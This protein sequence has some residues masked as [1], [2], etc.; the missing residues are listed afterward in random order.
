MKR[1]ISIFIMFIVLL[2]YANISCYALEDDNNDVSNISTESDFADNRVIIAL[3][4]KTSLSFEQYDSSDFSSIGC[5]Q[6]YDLSSGSETKV[7]NAINNINSHVLE[8]EELQKYD[9]VALGEYRKI[10]CLE[11]D[12][13]SKENVINVINKLKQMDGVEYASPDYVIKTCSTTTASDPYS[14]DYANDNVDYLELIEL[15]DAWEITRGS[16]SVRVGVMDSGIDAFHEDLQGNVNTVISGSFRNGSYVQSEGMD[17][18]YHGTAVAGVIGAKAN[19][20]KGLAGVCNNIELVSFIISDPHGDA[21]ASNAL[22]AFNHIVEINND[23]CIDNDIHIINLSLSWMPP[24]ILEPNPNYNA[25]INTGITNYGKLVVCSAGNKGVDIDDT[26]VYPAT[27]HCPNVIVVGATNGAD[28]RWYEVVKDKDGNDVVYETN[29]GYTSVDLFAPGY[30]I[31]TTFPDDKCRDSNVHIDDIAASCVETG[32]HWLSGTSFATP[33]VTGVA[34]LMLSINPNLTAVQLKDIITRTV[35]VVPALENY[36]VSGGRLNAYKAVRT[37]QMYYWNID[38]TYLQLDTTNTLYSKAHGVW[39]DNCEC[40]CRNTDLSCDSGLCE[41]ACD[42]CEDCHYYFTELH[43]Y[44]YIST[45]NINT[46]IARCLDCGYEY[47][48]AHNMYYA[49]ILGNLYNHSVK[50]SACG[51][52]YSEGHSWVLNSSTQKYICTDCGMSADSVPGIMS[53]PDPELEAYLASLSGEEL[54][55]F[56]ASLPEDQVARVT[57]LLPSDDEHLTE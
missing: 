52:S 21:F 51:Y 40:S 1:V 48:Q 46:H 19:N 38:S 33:F 6:V 50:C 30:R 44:T 8:G 56:I 17:S 15:Y 54:E 16:D 25:I 31:L 13:H 18:Q 57:A 39:Y 53:L 28:Q 27:Y 36:C 7:Q 11:L 20:G 2:S 32:Y 47:T 23:T 5:E 42:P 55:E 26:E 4:N 3:D 14:L 24:S 37:V 9:G 45:S 29:Y 12:T 34:A 35:D 43:N 10:L 49:R 41:Y 22:A